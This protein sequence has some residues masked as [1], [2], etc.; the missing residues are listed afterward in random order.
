MDPFLCDEQVEE[1][2]P[3]DWDDEETKFEV[4]N[5][6]DDLAE[7]IDFSNSNDF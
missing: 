1:L 5:Y 6:Y 3:F 2:I 7:G 4:E